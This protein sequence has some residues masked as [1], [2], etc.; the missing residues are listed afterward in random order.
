MG[1]VNLKSYQKAKSWS[2]R[3][4]PLLTKFIKWIRGD[5]GTFSFG[6]LARPTNIYKKE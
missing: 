3:L 2:F 5:K 1:Y 4:S 6:L